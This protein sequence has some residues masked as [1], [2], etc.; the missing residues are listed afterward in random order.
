MEELIQLIALRMLHLLPLLI[1]AIVIAN[2]MNEFGLIKRTTFLIR[3]IIKFSN[4]PEGA[5]ASVITFLASGSAGSAMLASFYE[6]GLVNE[7]ETLVA[8]FISS[9][10]SYLNHLFIY[11]IPVVL[12]L[13]GLTA[14][15]LYLGTR[16]TISLAVTLFAVLIGHFFLKK[17]RAH[18]LTEAKDERHAWQKLKDGLKYAVLVLKKIIPRLILIY[19][20]ATI[21]FYMGWLDL[22]KQSAEPATSFVNLPGEASTIIAL[23][24]IDPTSAVIWAGS[25][26]S[27]GIISPF[28]AVLALL[29]GNIASMSFMLFRHSLPGKIAYFGV[30]LGTKMAIYSAVINLIFT[31][32]AIKILL[33]M[34]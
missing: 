27:N 16:F 20:L 23:G 18:V 33:L 29:L 1:I 17:R 21:A 28:E 19:P 24:F 6:R 34:F 30:K 26:L 12:P 22:V 3:P 15:I 7:K 25:L 2:L 11:F 8:F 9:F 14:G 5:G 31:I 10:F 13:L 32:I 4:L